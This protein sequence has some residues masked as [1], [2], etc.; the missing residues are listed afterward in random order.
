MQ[1][2][3]PSGSPAAAMLC[4]RHLQLICTRWLALGPQLRA[5]LTRL[6]P[7]L[8]H[9]HCVAC[10]ALGGPH[11]SPWQQAHLPGPVPPGKT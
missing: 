3:C 1:G 4:L 7:L 11:W 9:K 6:Q 2:R 10:R 8:P 5:F